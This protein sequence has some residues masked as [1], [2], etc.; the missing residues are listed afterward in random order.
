MSDIVGVPPIVLDLTPSESNP[1]NSEGAFVTLADGSI[2]FAYSRYYGGRKD[3][4]AAVIG[5]RMSHDAGRTWSAEDRVLVENEGDINVMSVSLLRLADGRIAMF[6]LV[7]NR[8]HDCRPWV[9]FS[10]DEAQTW[11]QRQLVTDAPGYWVLNN[12]RVIQLR[13]GAN[14]GRIIVPMSYHRY[15]KDP[16]K[17]RAVDSRATAV[18]FLSD[19]GGG[20]WREAQDWWAIPVRSW[21]GLQEPGVVELSDGRIF[22]W[23]RTDTRCQW[24]M[25]SSDSGETWTP[26]QASEFRSPLSPMSIKRLP[27]SGDLLAIWVD[28]SGRWP[29]PEEQKDAHNRTPLACAISKDDCATWI[30]H[31]LLEND[32][33]R[34][35]CYIAIH[36]MADNHVLL[37]YCAGSK[38][39]GGHV[40]SRTVVRRIPI[41]WF[42]QTQ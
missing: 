22:A 10:R 5:S 28:H 32:P 12:D 34:G 17:E 30:N 3:D 23:S 13:R 37:A 35:F 21:S 15:T 1:R 33:E 24:T 4:A 14:A 27:G 7:K 29:V 18:F 25:G 11:S 19:D 16:R 40:L 38:Q 36:P 9:R 41:E 2:L 31:R 39:Y 20:T 26:P 42:Y 6:Y 8:P